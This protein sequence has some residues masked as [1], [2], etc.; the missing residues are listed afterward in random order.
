SPEYSNPYDAKIMMANVPR[1]KMKKYRAQR[2]A[3]ARIAEYGEIENDA[4]PRPCS[5][6]EMM[7]D[8]APTMYNTQPAKKS[9]R[10]L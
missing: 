6:A 2:F 4:T 8:A 7:N 3:A 9:M 1:V 10:V 5:Q